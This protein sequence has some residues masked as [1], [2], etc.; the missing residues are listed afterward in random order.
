MHAPDTQLLP[1]V[2]QVGVDVRVSFLLFVIQQEAKHE[3]P[4]RCRCLNHLRVKRPGEGVSDLDGKVEDD[5]RGS[6]HVCSTA[7]EFAAKRVKLVGEL[8]VVVAKSP[9]DLPD[10]VE[11]AGLKSLFWVGVLVH[12][13]WDDDRTDRLDV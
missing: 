5:F 13:D 2:D 7:S 6:T 4:G 8:V 3:K 1:A 11:L 12:E 9:D 10:T